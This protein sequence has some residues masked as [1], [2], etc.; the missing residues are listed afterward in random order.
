MN[1]KRPG[2]DDAGGFLVPEHDQE[3]LTNPPGK[4]DWPK[5]QVAVRLPKGVQLSAMSFD[6]C[7]INEKGERE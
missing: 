4:T 6:K 3:L 7:A 5:I 2:V 1:N